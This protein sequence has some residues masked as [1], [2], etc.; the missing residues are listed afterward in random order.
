MV[1]FD[2]PEA[3]EE[4]F[5]RTFCADNYIFNNHIELHD[6]SLKVISLF[7]IFVKH[8]INSADQVNQQRY[9]SKNNNNILRP[10]ALKK[11]FPNAVIIIP[12][13]DPV[14]QSISFLHQ[15]QKFSAIQSKDLLVYKYMNWLGHYEFG[16]RHKAFHFS[17]EVLD[18]TIDYAPDNINYWLTVWVNTYCHI[19]NSTP[20]ESLYVRFE[21]LCHSPKVITSNLFALASIPPEKYLLKENIKTPREKPV[22]NINKILR[23]KAANIHSALLEKVK[24]YSN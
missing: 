14:H 6:V 8:V 18:N 12:F 5:W 3:F 17:K 15:H 10:E 16:A 23:K 13:R 1:N 11:A 19:L 21:N 24:A 20:T 9:L 4:I 7:R 2:D 22:K